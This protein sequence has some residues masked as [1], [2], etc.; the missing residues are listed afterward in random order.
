M[1]LYLWLTLLSLSSCLMGWLTVLFNF[2]SG[3]EAMGGLAGLTE[4]MCVP[5]VLVFVAGDTPLDCC[6]GCFGGFGG[7]IYI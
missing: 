3:L 5:L 7:K 2:I 4:C 1:R 6:W